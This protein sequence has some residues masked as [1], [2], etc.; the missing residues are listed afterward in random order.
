MQLIRL[1]TN[2]F[3]FHQVSFLN[4]SPALNH[5][6][7]AAIL[8]PVVGGAIVGVMARYGSEKIR[9]HGIP[10]AIESIMVGGS[11]VEPRVAVLKPISSA[12]SIGSG[13]PFG[14]EGPI[15]MTGGAIG[16]LVAQ[17][18]DLTGAERKTLLVAGAAAGMAATFGTPAAAVLLAV[19]VMLFEWKPRSLVPVVLAS[20]VAAAARVPLL[21]SRFDF[22]LV[23]H[24]V[25]VAPPDHL[26]RA[27]TPIVFVG[28]AVAGLLGG[29][30]AVVA[31]RMV[32]ASE[33]VFVVFGKR[34][35]VHWA[36]WPIIGGAAVGLGGLLFPRAL[37]VG[38]D[39]IGL[40]LTQSQV[41]Y[42]LIAGVLI[43]K[44]VIWSFSLGSGTSGGVLAPLLM[45]GGA[46]G[47][48]EAHFLPPAG[49]GFWAMVS[50]SCVLGAAMR[51]PLAAVLFSCEI[52]HNFSMLG[53]LLVAT[54][55]A[56][57][58]S[59][60]V[61]RRSIL[62]EKVARRGYHLSC[63]YA[64]DPLEVLYTREVMR[65][66]AAVL[67]QNLP[68]A[69]FPRH[70]AHN[71]DRSQKLFP[72][73]DNERKIVGVISRAHLLE[74]S[75]A[76]AGARTVGD[77]A[78]NEYTVAYSHETLKRVAQRMA[79]QG[80]TRMPVLDNHASRRVAGMVCLEDLLKARV[81]VMESEQRRDTYLFPGK[82]FRRKRAGIKQNP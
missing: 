72:V 25:R 5:L 56:Y 11:R 45:I 29:L 34:F 60:L 74:E 15:I 62:T 10:E 51:A 23:M 48:L 16:S 26:L 73:V 53:P 69:D 9:G 43:V 33:D 55:C 39:T 40:L 37:G 4:R 3:F 6:G 58:V 32:Y 78:S 66:N 27:I 76:T 18:F 68:L 49:A 77:V 82:L 7:P 46:L 30:I 8:A 59:A 19:E 80:R 81:R 36:V 20:V 57:A 70:P 31:T 12:I 21:G 24:G 44:T 1:F 42:S 61:L 75:V 54:A 22:G 38:Y 41:A 52:T 35:N 63:E 50:M 67:E 47:A 71:A 64:I 14:A 28:C 79:E 65:A 17:F 2:L 13:G